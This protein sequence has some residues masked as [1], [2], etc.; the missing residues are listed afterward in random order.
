MFKKQALY[1]YTCTESQ[2]ALIETAAEKRLCGDQQAQMYY[3]L[4]KYKKLNSL[5]ATSQLSKN[6]PQNQEALEVRTPYS[7][8]SLHAFEAEV[9][10]TDITLLLGLTDLNHMACYLT[11]TKRFWNTRSTVAQ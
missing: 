11:I 1:I 2:S 10:H 6:Q 9:M 3:D 5:S 8:K 4:I 7:N